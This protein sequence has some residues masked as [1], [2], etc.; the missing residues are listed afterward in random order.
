MIERSKG[1]AAERSG[2]TTAPD[3]ATPQDIG[4][5]ARLTSPR[6]WLVALTLAAATAGAI[7]WGFRGEVRVDVSGLGL[8]EYRK[9]V[10]QELAA[11]A[12]GRIERIAVALGDS[13]REGDLIAVLQV[14]TDTEE[15]RAA[16]RVL[17]TLNAERT[18]RGDT[19]DREIARRQAATDATVAALETQATVMAQRVADL[20]PYVAELEVQLKQGFI[21]RVTVDQARE[22]LNTAQVDLATARSDVL[23][24]RADLGDFI[25]SQQ[26]ALDELDNQIVQAQN[27]VDELQAAVSE[28]SHIVAP[29]AG[30]IIGLEARA[31][32][33]LAAGSPVARLESATDTL[34]VYAYFRPSDG[35]RI[36]A[37]MAAQVSPGTVEP[38]IFGSIIGTVVSVAPQPATAA[39]LRQQIDNETMVQEFLKG[40]APIAVEIAL[41]ANPA[42]A[43]G[44]AWTSSVGPPFRVSAGTTAATRVTVQAEPPVAFIIPIFQTWLGGAQR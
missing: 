18:R 1:Q 13:V 2:R 30:R 11:P 32:D 43:S 41:N 28:S 8:I 4:R 35:K 23:S 40:G 34:Q 19:V 44:L 38:E 42:T 25:A 9:G 7:V 39:E 22:S 26:Q 24:A 33:E 20:Q 14:G 37:G 31:G 5:L 29:R 15:L 36:S 27:N 10:L 21:P 6:G 3:S 17:A 16:Q 12:A